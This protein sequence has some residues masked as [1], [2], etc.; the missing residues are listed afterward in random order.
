MHEVDQKYSLKEKNTH[1][2]L[3]LYQV[4]NLVPIQ[5]QLSW[6]RL[7][8]LLNIAH[9]FRFLHLVGAHFVYLELKLT[10]VCECMHSYLHVSNYHNTQGTV[11][12]M[13]QTP[14]RKLKFVIQTRGILTLSGLD[15]KKGAQR[16]KAY[17]FCCK[18]Q[19]L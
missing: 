17:C 6:R 18:W 2:W 13:L 16:G 15:R 12:N 10:I 14:T 1:T 5:Y 19:Y 3:S 9:L 8:L 11:H 4:A 7:C